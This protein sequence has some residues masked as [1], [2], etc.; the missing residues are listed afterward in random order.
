MG[1]ENWEFEVKMYKGVVAIDKILHILGPI[2]FICAIRV[3]QRLR[4]TSAVV[5]F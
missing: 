1:I 3:D 2:W 4:R 5:I